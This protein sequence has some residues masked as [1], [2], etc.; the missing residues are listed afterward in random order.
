MSSFKEGLFVELK[1]D[2]KTFRLIESFSYYR[3]DDHKDTITVPIDFETDFASV[4]R[5]FTPLIEKIGRHSKA[6]VIHDY[7]YS[8]T[9][10]RTRKECDDIFLE[11]M[12]VS[13]VNRR[14]AYIMYYGVRLFGWT[15]Y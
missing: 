9:S 8:I 6:A 13:N 12:L 14:I 2:G 3:T 5:I 4:P 10:L 1:P 15:R 11:A 7:L